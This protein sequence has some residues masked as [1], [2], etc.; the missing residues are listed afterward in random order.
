MLK[1]IC[2]IAHRYPDK[3]NPTVHVFVR[4]LAWAMA[5]FGKEVTVISPVPFRLKRGKEKVSYSCLEIS[6]KGSMIRIY[7]PSYLYVGNRHLG[8]IHTGRFSV[9]SMTKACRKVIEEEH[10]TPDVFYGHFVCPAGITACRLGKQYG[11]P[12]YI[13]FGESTDIPLLLY[14]L[15]SVRRETSACSGFIAVSGHNRDRLLKLGL[16]HPN[17]CKVFPNGIDPSVYYPK[18]KK[19]AR[20]RYGFPENAF[21]V[22]YVGQFSNRKGILRLVRAVESVKDVF[23][24]CAGNGPLKP[25]GARVLFCNRVAADEIPDFLSASDLFVLPTRNEGC[26]NAVVEAMA[27]GLPV[28][29]ADKAFV[30]D[31]LDKDS[32]ILVDPDNIQEIS[33]AI[34]KM[35]EDVKFRKACAE[36]SLQLAACLTIQNR[37]SQICAWIEESM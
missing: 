15:D 33:A 27:C 25:S 31:I 28:I 5:D 36:R 16:V 10:L 29:T 4:K 21:I 9:W 20:Q 22:S 37:V 18:D 7:R 8:G 6:G 23:L 35:K 3:A 11:K 13:A 2:I 12:A 14:G 32:A 24:I 17:E 19:A 1:N 26:P 34:L 30:Y